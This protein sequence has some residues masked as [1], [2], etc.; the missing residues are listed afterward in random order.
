M[1]KEE[2]LKAFLSYYDVKRYEVLIK[3]IENVIN[4]S[5]FTQRNDSQK[6]DEIFKVLHS[7]KVANKMQ[8]IYIVQPRSKK[9]VR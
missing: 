4:N 9:G 7:F 8:P 2:Y 6:V 1:I 3:I 5:L